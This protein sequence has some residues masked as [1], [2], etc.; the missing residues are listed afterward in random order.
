MS[1][2]LDSQLLREQT[3]KERTNTKREDKHEKREQ[4]QNLLWLQKCKHKNG[5]E[6]VTQIRI[7]IKKEKKYI[8]ITERQ[9]KCKKLHK[10]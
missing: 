7:T 10:K 3:Q 5:E 8:L 6:I 4:T 1:R 9:K 2:T